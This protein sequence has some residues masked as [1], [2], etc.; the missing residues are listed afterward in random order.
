M[1]YP[2]LTNGPPLCEGKNNCTNKG[3]ISAANRWLCADCYTHWVVHQEK[4][5]KAAAD[6]AFK[7]EVPT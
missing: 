7:T 5:R 4:L 6:E 1:N 3:W 2:D